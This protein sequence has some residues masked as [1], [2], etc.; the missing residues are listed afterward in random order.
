MERVSVDAPDCQVVLSDDSRKR[1]SS[2]WQQRPVALVF[3]RFF[4]CPFG[5]RQVLQ[6]CH[7]EDALRNAGI[8]VVLVSSGT[9]AQA[10]VFRRDYRVPFT[11]ICDPD[12]ALFKKYSLRE[13]T[14][15]DYLSPR[16]HVKTI[17]VLAQGYGH[18]SGEGSEAQLGGVSIIDTSGKAAYAHIAADA[19]D[20]PSPQEIVQAASTLTANAV[21]RSEH[22]EARTSDR[23][24]P[25]ARGNPKTDA[26]GE[27]SIPPEVIKAG[28]TMAFV[29]Y[30]FFPIPLLAGS[31]RR[32]AFV[33]YHTRQAIPMT[34]IN[35]AGIVLASIG[36][37]AFSKTSP[38]TIIGSVLHYAMFV[39]LIVGSVNALRGKVKPLPLLGR[40]TASLRF[41]E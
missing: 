39:L 37:F 33:M 4:G 30:L 32:N 3:P 35:L 17:H 38:I 8:D 23:E 25:L 20:H 11:V 41:L 15:R 5:R 36:I 6:L 27:V 10:E 26:T 31:C 7:E 13:M 19:A 12:R 18:K 14:L 34:A 24:P 28:K 16:M 1:L 2:F 9:P 21:P 29:A 22:V 40:L